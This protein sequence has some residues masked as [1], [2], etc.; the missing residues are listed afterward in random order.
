LR[1]GGRRPLERRGLRLPLPRRAPLSKKTGVRVDFFRTDGTGW[2]SVDG[3]VPGGRC[4]RQSC[5]GQ[6]APA[7]SGG[8][9]VAP[10]R[11]DTWLCGEGAGLVVARGQEVN[12][13]PLKPRAIVAD[14]A[15]PALAFRRGI[16]KQVIREAVDVQGRDGGAGGAVDGGLRRGPSGRQGGRAGGAADRRGRPGR[17][18]GDRRLQARQW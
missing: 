6:V 15:C 10:L 2:P 12:L 9:S 5:R 16:R 11:W 7:Q 13:T 17:R 1:R 8:E 4:A 14:K 3:A 18:A